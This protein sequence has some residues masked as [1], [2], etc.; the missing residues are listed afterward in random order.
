MSSMNRR[1]LPAGLGRGGDA[2]R[3]EAAALAVG[4]LLRQVP[5]LAASKAPA[6]NLLRIRPAAKK[7]KS[8]TVITQGPC[9]K[10][11]YLKS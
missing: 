8:R 5:A 1:G 11:P 9:L 4:A 2:G 3:G 10:V 6:A 7:V